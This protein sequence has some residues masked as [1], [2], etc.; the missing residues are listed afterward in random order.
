LKLEDVFKKTREKVL[1]STDDKQVPWE[2]SSIT[3]D[4]YFTM[5]VDKSSNSILK[6]EPKQSV[7]LKKFPNRNKFKD[8]D[9]VPKSEKID[10]VKN[11]TV[12]TGTCRLQI[13]EGF[14]PCDGKVVFFELDNGRSFITFIKDGSIFMVAGGP[15]RQPNLNNYYLAIDTFRI[16][17]NGNLTAEDKNMEGECH[18]ELSD[19]ASEFFS[20]KCDVYNR[21]KGAIFKLYLEDITSTLRM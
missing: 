18:F 5:A 13:V 6:T 2:T 17:K 1:A 7:V 4:F 16:T 10:G 21:E 15:D 12:F 19:D 14:F 11:H 9:A 3:G 20:V 8:S